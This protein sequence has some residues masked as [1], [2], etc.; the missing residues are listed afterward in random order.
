MV[1]KYKGYCP[2]LKK[3]FELSVYYLEEATMSG[4]QYIREINQC[5][6]SSECVEEDCPIYDRAPENI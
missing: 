3:D 5:K 4:N 2:Y 1:R 6:F